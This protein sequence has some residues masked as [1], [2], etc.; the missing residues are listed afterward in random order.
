M[1]QRVQAYLLL[2]HCSEL[3]DAVVDAVSTAL[4]VMHGALRGLECTVWWEPVHHSLRGE[5]RQ[6]GRSQD[7][8][9]TA[10][11]EFISTSVNQ[12][13]LRLKGREPVHHR[14]RPERAY[15]TLVQC[16][17]F[18][19]TSQNYITIILSCDVQQGRLMCDI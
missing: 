4:G 8:G 12:Y 1:D 11:R 5:Q 3:Q 7:L 6:R 17:G 2:Q 16:P 9:A 15:R 19:Y 18:E 14:L 13:R 10:F